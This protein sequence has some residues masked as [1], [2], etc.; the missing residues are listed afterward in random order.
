MSALLAPSR[1]QVLAV[2]ARSLELKW[3]GIAWYI[4]G[5]VKH[6]LQTYP[7]LRIELF[8]QKPLPNSVLAGHPNL[9]NV[10][11]TSPLFRRLK[12]ILWLKI[13]GSLLTRRASATCFWGAAGLLPWGLKIPSA[14]TVHDLNHR[15]VPE[16][17]SRGVRLAYGAFLERD[18]RAA[19][20]VFTNSEGTARRL[21]EATGVV[22]AGVIHPEMRASLLDAIPVRPSGL[23]S[24]A[25]FFLCAATAEPRK[26]MALSI[27]AFLTAR[28]RGLVGE[29]SLVLVGDT[30]WKNDALRIHL[31]QAGGKVACHLGYVTNEELAWLYRNCQA[32]LFP[33]AYE[34]F[35]MPVQEARCLGARIVCTDI[36]E[37]REAG[38]DHC[39]YV[40][41]D[42]ENLVSGLAKAS[43]SEKA[44]FKVYDRDAFG[45]E[46]ESFA[47]QLLG[48]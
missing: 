17:M 42:L 43:N 41:P 5:I 33:S 31:A 27:E 28:E 26:N 20:L 4:N 10:F 48:T 32:F 2:D 34:G 39:I 19:D 9:G 24:E 21:R 35:G 11:E 3:A 47:Q 7:E 8:T 16:T 30:G 22:A 44:V 15:L 29:A 1:Q 46:V 6:L 13:R 12:P 37:I 14:V 36:P 38:D 23:R 25:P 45:G 18:A 40:Q